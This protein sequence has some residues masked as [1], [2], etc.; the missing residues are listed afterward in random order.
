MKRMISAL[1]LAGLIATPVMAQTTPHTLPETRY[2]NV[3][4]VS[5]GI[6]DEERD[7]IRRREPD[8]NLKLLFS[9]RDGSYMAGVDV[10]LL[11]AKGETI[12]EAKAAGP[13][14]LARVPPGNYVVKLSANGQAQQGKLS[15]SAKGQR[16]AV[17]RW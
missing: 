7:E 10:Q 8:F 3:S 17:F 13:F 16:Q 2:G 11:N 1:L 9:E 15:V 6:G 5:G 12:L 14:L 4:Y